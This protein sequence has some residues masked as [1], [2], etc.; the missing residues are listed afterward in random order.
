MEY[1]KVPVE[2]GEGS[3]LLALVLQEERALVHS[4]LFQVPAT[5]YI[6]FPWNRRRLDVKSFRARSK[7]SVSIKANPGEK[8]FRCF[9]GMMMWRR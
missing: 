8:L 6:K 4:E 2:A 1:L 9:Q 7:C 5:T 3:M